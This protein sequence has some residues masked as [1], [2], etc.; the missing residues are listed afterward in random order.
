MAD[1]LRDNTIVA[2]VVH[3][4]I[5]LS[6]ERIEWLTVPGVSGERERRAREREREGERE[7]HHY[8]IHSK[9]L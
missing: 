8:I 9:N 2:F 6:K 7:G 4:L 5:R 1:L 3:Q